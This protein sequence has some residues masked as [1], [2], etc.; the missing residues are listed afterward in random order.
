MRIHAS[1]VIIQFVLLPVLSPDPLAHPSRRSKVCSWGGL[2]TAGAEARGAVGIVISGRETSL[3]IAQQIFRP[4]S[5]LSAVDV[6]LN[7]RPKDVGEGPDV[8]ASDVVTQEDEIVTDEEV[9]ICVSVDRVDKVVEL[10][11][12]GQE[13]YARYMADIK[14]GK[15]I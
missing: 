2:M 6:T 7:I 1:I 12:K 15:G 11:K 14:A 9:V 8:F 13:V 10:A 5:Y 3:N 4:L